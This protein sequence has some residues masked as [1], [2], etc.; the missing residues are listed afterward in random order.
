MSMSIKKLVFGLWMVMSRCSTQRRE[1]RNRFHDIFMYLL[2]TENSAIPAME[3]EQ[4]CRDVVGDPMPHVF[5]LQVF[6]L[7]SFEIEPDCEVPLP[8]QLHNIYLG[9]FR[10][11]ISIFLFTFLIS[12]VFL[13]RVELC[14]TNTVCS[15]PIFP[16]KQTP[17]YPC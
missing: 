8:N 2:P 9:N 7:R 17:K 1:H 14:L 16:R 6:L 3:D 11:P 5:A 15:A 13:S 12:F 4:T 10:F